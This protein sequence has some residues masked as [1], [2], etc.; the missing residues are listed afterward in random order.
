MGVELR[1]EMLICWGLYIFIWDLL[2]MGT[3]AG[4]AQSLPAAR[5]TQPRTQPRLLL[6]GFFEGFGHGF[7]SGIGLGDGEVAMVGFAAFGGY[8]ARKG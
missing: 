4:G 6:A 8:F 3:A 5:G 1:A 7:V 2:S